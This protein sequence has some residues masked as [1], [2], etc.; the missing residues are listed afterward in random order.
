VEHRTE[1]EFTS[2]GCCAVING[3]KCHNKT[4]VK[5]V[6]TKCGTPHVW[7]KPSKKLRAHKP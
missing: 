3:V 6:C 2:L 7:K 5:G 1:Q 4:H